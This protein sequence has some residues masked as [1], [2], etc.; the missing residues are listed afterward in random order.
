MLQ[1]P[2]LSRTQFQP[3]FSIIYNVCYYP[4]NKRI[5]YY[6]VSGEVHVCEGFYITLLTYLGPEADNR[7]GLHSFKGLCLAGSIQLE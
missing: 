2:D 6:A 4:E 1:G 3:I 7:K 5:E